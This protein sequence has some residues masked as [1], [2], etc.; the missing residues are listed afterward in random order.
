MDEAVGTAVG[1]D[2][3]GGLTVIFPDGHTETLTSGE[4]S[5]RFLQ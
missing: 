5:L 4:I 1:I 2:D 3:N